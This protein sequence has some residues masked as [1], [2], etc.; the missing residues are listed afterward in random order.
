MYFPAASPTSQV[1]KFVFY[2][3][4]FIACLSLNSFTF[5]NPK[6]QIFS[7]L[8]SLVVKLCHGNREKCKAIGIDL[9]TTNSCVAVWRNNHVEI[10]PNDQG[11]RT[12]PS[13]VAFTDTQRLVGDAAIK[14][15]DLN[16]HNT[17]FDVKR[18]IRRRFSDQSVQQDMKL[19]PFKVVPGARDKP[20]IA[21]TY[22][23]EERKLAAEEISSMVLLKLKEVAEAYL[24]HEVTRAVITVPAYFN[25]SQRQATKDAGEIAGFN[26]VRIMN[27][28]TAAAI[29]YALNK[30][31]RI[32]GKQNV[33]VYD[34]GG[35]T[36][37]VSLVTLEDGMIEVKATVGDTHLG[38][39]DF[40][41]NLVNNIVD[42]FKRNKTKDISENA[43]AMRMLTSA[44]EKAKRALCY[45]SSTLILLKSLLE[46]IDLHVPVTREDF[47]F[48]NMD[49]FNGCMETVEKCLVEAK[50]DKSEVHEVV[51]VGGSTRIPMVRQL[52]NDMFYC[53]YDLVSGLCNVINPDEAVA[54]GAAVRAAMLNGEVEDMLLMDVVAHS[55]GVEINGG[56]MSVV[57]PRN[58]ML[59]TKNERAF[60]INFNDQN[61]SYYLSYVRDTFQDCHNLPNEQ[62]ST[63]LGPIYDR[64]ESISLHGYK[65]RRRCRANWNSESGIRVLIKVYEGEESRTNDNLFLGE[66]EVPALPQI[67]VCFEVDS[68]GIVKVT[69]EGKTM[70]LEGRL[71]A[72]EIGRDAEW[73]KEK[74]TFEF[75]AHEMSNRLKKLENSAYETSNSLKKLEKGLEVVLESIDI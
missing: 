51:L 73:Y 34:L 38:G 18:L 70:R 9:G 62:L 44:C 29:T 64:I 41:N 5:W 57:V 53:G 33:L 67:N 49:M 75:S 16:P 17:I 24:G 28:P 72:E 4:K 42:A 14:Q 10:I 3:Y 68:G 27:E 19:W 12:T 1:Y 13:C 47:E 46:G 55:V 39:V 48:L 50:I 69:A 54:Y 60:S 58:T 31:E 40:S 71:S 7:V 2:A 11:R 65:L 25:N 20:L 32:E 45:D 66:I 35:G 74:D 30:K 59:P 23:G 22:K 36:L 56:V 61:C 43:E 63:I 21:V 26:V 8:C 6:D 37:D 15:L 52:L